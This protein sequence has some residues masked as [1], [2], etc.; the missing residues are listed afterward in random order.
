M[1]N[2]SEPRQDRIRVLLLLMTLSGA[3]ALRLTVLVN[4]ETLPGWDPSTHISKALTV[5]SEGHLATELFW[6]PPGFHFL[7]AT[8]FLFAG[9]TT[10][11]QATFLLIKLFI[12]TI[13]AVQ[14]LV[15]Y[16]VGR[17][18]YGSPTVGLI[19]ALLMTVSL[20]Q[21]EMLGWGGYP[22]IT[23]MLLMGLALYLISAHPGRQAS[24]TISTLSMIFG[25]IVSHSISTF[26]FVAVVL[27]HLFSFSLISRRPLKREI[28]AAVFSLLIVFGFYLTFASKHILF[29]LNLISGYS[30]HIST[31]NPYVETFGELPAYLTP[32]GVLSTLLFARERI[33]RRRELALLISWLLVPFALFQTNFIAR[34]ANRFSY[35]MAYPMAFLPAFALKFTAEKAYPRIA[36][37]TPGPLSSSSKRIISI[38]LCLILSAAGTIYLVSGVPARTSHYASYYLVCAPRDYDASILERTK[39]PTTANILAAYPAD[40]WISL[41][42]E[43]ETSQADVESVNFSMENPLTE[44]E[45]TGPY[46]V[47]R[48]PS[49]YL[50]TDGESYE[51][52]RLKDGDLRIEFVAHDSERHSID[53]SESYYEKVQWAQ[54]SSESISLRYIF[55]DRFYTL[56]K[57]VTIRGTSPLV[58]FRYRITPNSRLSS[59]NLTLNMVLNRDLHYYSLFIPGFFAWLNPW[60]NPTARDRKGQFAYVSFPFTK[61]RDR[62]F[63]LLD[64]DR[65]ALL[66]IRLGVDPLELTIGARSDR[67]IDSVKATYR[68]GSVSRGEQK[69]LAFDILAI[70]LPRDT[71][72]SEMSRE[73]ILSL[74]EQESRMLLESR[75]YGEVVAS[76]PAT[77][78]QGRVGRLPTGYL[79]DPHFNRIF[80][81]GLSNLYA[82][83]RLS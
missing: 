38:A 20:R 15:V 53:L 74:I 78:I 83:R 23:G 41:L 18:V 80:D 14:I 79:S 48:N 73:R 27:F 56:E 45:E 24:T 4:Y 2:L 54:R 31:T 11:T 3:F 1:Q 29:I 44:V 22:N 70:P 34:F 30:P 75:D 55:K 68:Y 82:L 72:S 42:T 59:L 40:P 36:R 9:L 50:K 71:A 28:L 46:N 51:A 81:N 26:V 35:F 61:I 63:A 6:Y 21:I 47:G 57:L 12:A 33:D 77:H 69:D 49:L 76:T 25:L 32:I 10:I 17:R 7:L 62:F 64:E 58:E 67:R 65:P 19:G 39:T 52:L 66:A 13:S 37:R 16:L 60:D 5:V 43:R 8:L